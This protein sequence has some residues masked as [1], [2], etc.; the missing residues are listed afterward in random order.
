MLV[1]CPECGREISSQAIRCPGCGYKEPEHIYVVSEETRQEWKKREE[2]W[3][4]K[5][6]WE[7]FFLMSPIIFIIIWTV[8]QCTVVG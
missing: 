3:R 6:N 4:V 1:S 8:V 2:Q 5:E 7:I